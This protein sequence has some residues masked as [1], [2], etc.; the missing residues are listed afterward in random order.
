[1]FTWGRGLYLQLGHA[2]DDDKMHPTRV[3][4]SLRGKKVVALSVNSD[5]SA[6]VGGGLCKLH[7]VYP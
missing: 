2:N 5:Y 4:G 1:M 7:P 6:A 3:G